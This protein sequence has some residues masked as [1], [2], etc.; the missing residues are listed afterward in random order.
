MLPAFDAKDTRAAMLPMLL[1]CL[2]ILS[3]TLMNCKCA[4][5]AKG[6]RRKTAEQTNQEGRTRVRVLP[7]LFCDRF[8]S[9]SF[10][11]F[12]AT[13]RFASFLA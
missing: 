10:L 2:R 9:L 8:F 12:L 3:A 4:N 13:W 7:R 6:G 11:A 5:P 1:S